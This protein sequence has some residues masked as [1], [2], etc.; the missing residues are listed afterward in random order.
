MGCMLFERWG[1]TDDELLLT[2]PGDDLLDRPYL[3][4]TRSVTVGGTPSETLTWLTQMGTGR[5]GWYSYDLIDNFGR[6]SARRLNDEWRVT[7]A[8]ETIPAGPIS[9][10]VVH[11]VE[12]PPAEFV[13]AVADHTVA[14]HTIGFTLAYRAVAR[15]NGTQTR[16][17]SRARA[18]VSGPLSTVINPLLAAGDGLMVRRQLLGLQKRCGQ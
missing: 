5:A 4:A 1:A 11:L 10:D 13:L 3:S 17:I 16:L 18:H 8:G 9:F 14:G 15:D 12:G 2:L 7:E 6:P